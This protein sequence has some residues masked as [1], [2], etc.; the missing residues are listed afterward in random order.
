MIDQ[1]I[2]PEVEDPPTPVT[3]A[4]IRGDREHGLDAW[5]AGSTPS[6][7]PRWIG[8]DG[9]WLSR[10]DLLQMRLDIADG[11]GTVGQRAAWQKIIDAE[12]AYWAQLDAAYESAKLLLA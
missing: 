4:R 3:L 5:L 7:S 11:A 10:A 6:G 12:A 1:P 9:R 8:D 2:E